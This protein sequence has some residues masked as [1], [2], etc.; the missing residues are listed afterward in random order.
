MM[1]FPLELKNDQLALQNSTV[2]EFTKEKSTGESMGYDMADP[3][4]AQE[5]RF[6]MGSAPP[7]S[8][9]VPSAFA[10]LRIRTP[11]T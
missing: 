1:R 9:R 6:R 2:D 11:A 7:I 8:S 3:A 4:Q 10:S 5:A